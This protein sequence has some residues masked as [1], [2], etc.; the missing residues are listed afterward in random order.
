MI[1]PLGDRAERFA[2]GC[3]VVVAVAGVVVAISEAVKAVA[4]T[5][6]ALSSGERYVVVEQ[7]DDEEAEA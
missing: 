7:G 6:E 3:A 4:E 1:R 5:V 2:L